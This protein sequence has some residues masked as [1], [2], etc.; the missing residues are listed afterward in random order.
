MSESNM[1]E[2]NVATPQPKAPGSGLDFSLSE[3]EG[4]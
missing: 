3:A 1:Y 2:S 4:L